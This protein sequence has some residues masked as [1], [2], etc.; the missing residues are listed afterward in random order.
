MATILDE[1]MG[2]LQMINKDRDEDIAA[3]KG[4][5]IDRPAEFTA[6][7]KIG[8]KRP[9]RTPQT[10]CVTCW[11]SRVEGKKFWMAGAIKD[12][13]GNVLATGESLFIRVPRSRL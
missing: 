13:E 8:Y 5:K 6:E 1:V 9:V 7:L 10:V 4:V 12:A 3:A 2:V 11:Y